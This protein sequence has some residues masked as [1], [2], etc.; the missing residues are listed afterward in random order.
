MDT[1]TIYIVTIVILVVIF[2]LILFGIVV[3]K[4]PERFKSFNSK[5][6]NNPEN[7][8]SEGQFDF[9]DMTKPYLSDFAETPLRNIT[10]LASGRSPY[11]TQIATTWYDTQGIVL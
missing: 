11:S 5:K 7:D 10:G 9:V 1:H 8:E 2:L 3:G 6:F 4:W